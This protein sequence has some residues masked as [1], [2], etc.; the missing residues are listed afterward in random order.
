MSFTMSVARELETANQKYAA[1]FTKGDL[2][3]PPA[4]FVWNIHIRLGLPRLMLC[5]IGK[6]RLSHAW[7]RV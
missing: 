7:M 3:L 6:L 1:E 5:M 2:A 4:R